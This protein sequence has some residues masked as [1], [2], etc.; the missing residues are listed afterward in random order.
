MDME[1]AFIGITDELSEGSWVDFDGNAFGS[2]AGTG[3][4]TVNGRYEN[5]NVNEPNNDGNEDYATIFASSGNWN[6]HWAQNPVLCQKPADKGEIQI[7]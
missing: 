5:F 7:S 6:D 4:T 3:F 1:K 2:G